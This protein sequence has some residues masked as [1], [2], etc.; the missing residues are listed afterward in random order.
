M[1]ELRWR[2]SA[3]AQAAVPRTSAE[4]TASRVKPT[5]VD[6]AL[7]ATA[8]GDA[9][10]FATLYDECSTS[11]YGL[12]RRIVR[13]RSQS[14]EVLQEV[15]LEVWR[16][17]PRFDPHL[18]SAWAWIMTIAH[19]RAV[20]R[21]RS[22]VAERTRV[23]RVTSKVTPSPGTVHEEVVDEL[24][25]QRVRGAL[26]QLTELQRA[27]I[28]L[29]Y[30][31]GLT[32]TEIADAPRR[33]PRHREDANP[34][35]PDPA[36]RR[37]WR[38]N[39]NE[40]LHTLV[41][42]YVVDALDDDER[43]QFEAHLVDCP[44]CAADVTEFRATTS[45]LA[46]LVAETPPPALRATIM[47]RIATTRQVSPV[48]MLGERRP[49]PAAGRWIAPVLVAAAAV[50]ALILGL[51]LAATHRD[52]DRQQ[53]LTAVLTAPDATVVSLDGKAPGD[54]RVVYSPSLE[55]SAV[56]ADG[57]ADVPSDRTYALWF[58]GDSGPQEAGL[59][60]TDEGHAAHLIDGTPEG[61]QALGVTEEPA[62]GSPQ[63]T[64]PI[65]FTGEV[66][67]TQ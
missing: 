55:R 43:E 37:P 65:L 58:I 15:M 47:D 22:E 67:Q 45:R 46:T 54:M 53:A 49:R 16:L 41:G 56:V 61:Y 33:P 12:I 8:Q 7:R 42:P 52:L 5:S 6:V 3:S 57:M 31:G 28:E 26:D 51:G 34:R 48:A 50:V 35:R 44:A 4:V 9:I 2:R 27:S 17:A 14:D 24:D 1:R 21:V 23:D 40:D 18:G 13:D 10:A 63:P 59:F 25:R 60:R 29:A 19:R 36:A 20:D 38:R 11:V 30:Y 64:G 39:V 62:G 66:D 32:Q